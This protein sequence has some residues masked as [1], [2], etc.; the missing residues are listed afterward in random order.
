MTTS[1]AASS[2]GET[3]IAPGTQTGDLEQSLITLVYGNG[4]LLAQKMLPI[5]MTGIVLDGPANFYVTLGTG[6]AFAS[7]V[8]RYAPSVF[9]ARHTRVCE[10]LGEHGHGCAGD[11]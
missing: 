11:R 6:H 8:A 2:V 10:T 5:K 7:Y 3:E 1:I 9:R 4:G